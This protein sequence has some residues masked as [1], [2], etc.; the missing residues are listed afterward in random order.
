[1]GFHLYHKGLTAAAI[2]KEETG[3]S[4]KFFILIK[5]Q[6]KEYKDG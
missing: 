4:S 5:T 2:K 3:G 6:G 1:M